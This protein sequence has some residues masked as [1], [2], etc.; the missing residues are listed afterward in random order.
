MTDKPNTQSDKNKFNQQNQKAE[1]RKAADNP[2][3]G[4]AT[5][6]PTAVTQQDKPVTEPAK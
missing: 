3:Q 5:I 4:E 6:E 1:E 2:R